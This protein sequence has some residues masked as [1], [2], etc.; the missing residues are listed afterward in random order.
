MSD[1]HDPDA[2]D[3]CLCGHDCSEHEVTEDHDLPEAQGGVEGDKKPRRRR[4]TRTSVED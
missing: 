4:P 3:G 1:P 2:H